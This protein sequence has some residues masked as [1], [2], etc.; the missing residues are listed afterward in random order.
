MGFRVCDFP[1]C[2]R[3]DNGKGDGKFGSG[4]NITRGEFVT[5]L[6]RVA[7][8]DLSKYSA[9]VFTDVDNGAFYAGA[10]GW[11]FENGIAKGTGNNKFSPNAGIT[12][13]DMAVMI[14]NF[15]KALGYELPKIK[16][17]LQ[18]ADQDKISSYAAEAA[19]AL[20]QA[21]IIE[22]RASGDT[23]DANTGRSFAPK[24]NA[25][26]AETAKILTLVIKG[27]VN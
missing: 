7:G 22:G 23:S 11:A 15:S 14:Q 2:K 26:R 9:S 20:Q 6:A 18:F 27:M 12:R 1:C 4:D 25:T 21:G 3:I 19:S 13:Q 10:V 16:D 5:L 8:V 17:N 24:D